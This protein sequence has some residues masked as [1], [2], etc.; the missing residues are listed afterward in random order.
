M[1]IKVA[2]ILRQEEHFLRPETYYHTTFHNL[3][4]PQHIE[5]YLAGAINNTTP[6]ILTNIIIQ[7]YQYQLFNNTI[8]SD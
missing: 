1:H 8:Y 6:P 3:D 2:A 7:A 5:K 4:S